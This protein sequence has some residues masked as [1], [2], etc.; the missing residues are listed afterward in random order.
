MR[1]LII[2]KEPR[3][4][5]L[6]ALCREKGH[7]LPTRGPWD[8]AVLPLPRSE[9]PEE[10]ADALP[11]GQKIVCGLTSPELEALAE[12]HRW[13]LLRVLQ[14]E[15]YTQEN[16]VL[17]AEGAVHAAMSK[18]D[19]ALAGQQCLVLGYGRIGQ[20]LTRMLRGL[21]VRVTVAAR[22][23]E[24]RVA[25]GPDSIPLESVP[26]WLP[27]ISLLFNTV[28]APL[29][30][31]KELSLLPPAA[32]LFELASPPYGIDLAAAKRLCLAAYLESGLPGRYCPQ[33][34]AKTLLNYLEREV[35]HHE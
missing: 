23:P 14:D 33:S 31:E 22:R 3:D 19:R 7:A 4:V 28:P 32:Q 10:L 34:A 25:A 9:M 16:A 27:R 35:E 30:T 20:A 8:L 29:L 12:Q 1:I 17:T 6:S 24:S 11:A 13:K 5:Y 2:G 21:G 15:Q 26:D 18:T